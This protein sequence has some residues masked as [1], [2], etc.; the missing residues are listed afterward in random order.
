MLNHNMLTGIPKFK[1]DDMQGVC[2]ACQFGKRFK[3]ALPHDQHVRGCKFH[4]T[5]I[6]DHTRKI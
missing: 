3:A 4:V 2:E 6:N 1:V 5:F